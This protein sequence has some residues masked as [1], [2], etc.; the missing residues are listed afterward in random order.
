MIGHHR[1]R[2]AAAHRIEGEH[3]PEC[4]VLLVTAHRGL[5][6]LNEAVRMSSQLCVR[7]VTPLL[8]FRNCFWRRVGGFC[9]REGNG[10]RALLVMCGFRNRNPLDAVVFFASSA[11]RIPQIDILL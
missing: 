7:L 10:I 9:Q 2:R 6:F 11:M 4:G 1:Q 8:H 5:A 3:A